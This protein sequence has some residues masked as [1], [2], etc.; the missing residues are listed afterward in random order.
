MKVG[1]GKQALVFLWF[2]FQ[3][4]RTAGA[5]VWT[6]NQLQMQLQLQFSGTGGMTSDSNP[7]R[8]PFDCK[9]Q[10]TAEAVSHKARGESARNY[11]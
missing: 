1:N 3:S 10:E 5:C 2:C 4:E 6:A 8:T 11:L 9:V 7:D